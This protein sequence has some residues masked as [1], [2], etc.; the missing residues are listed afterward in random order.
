V[1]S[2]TRTSVSTIAAITV[3]SHGTAVTTRWITPC[4]GDGK[5]NRHGYAHRAVRTGINDCRGGWWS[6]GTP[7]ACGCTCR[8]TSRTSR[9]S[10]RGFDAGQRA[11]AKAEEWPPRATLNARPDRLRRQDGRVLPREHR[12]ALLRVSPE[13]K[14]GRQ[15][16]QGLGVPNGHQCLAASGRLATQGGATQVALFRPRRP[17]GLGAGRPERRLR[18]VRQ[19]PGQA[20]SLLQPDRHR[21]VVRLHGR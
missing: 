3:G 2:R 18:R 21:D 7:G 12:V 13:G 11:A 9:G 10:A 8:P 17:P 16:A 15:A 1:P 14:R 4:G 20:R 6:T 5:S 19:R